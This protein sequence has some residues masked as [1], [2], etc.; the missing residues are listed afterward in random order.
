MASTSW[1][2]S[3]RGHHVSHHK[4]SC[5]DVGVAAASGYVRLWDPATTGPP[6][7][8][9]PPPLWGSKTGHRWL[10]GEYSC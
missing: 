1:A 4:R 10:T 5:A 7:S 3:D 8:P 2:R 6:A 9:W